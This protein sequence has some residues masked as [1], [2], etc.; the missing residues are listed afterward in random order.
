M[1]GDGSQETRR[2]WLEKRTLGG[3]DDSES[4]R[5]LWRGCA[6]QF[7]NVDLLIQHLNGHKER[8][9]IAGICPI[10]ECEF[11]EFVEQG[12]LGRH[13]SVHLHQLRLMNKGVQALKKRLE[14]KGPGSYYECKF[15]ANAKLLFD[16]RAM[17]CEWE[18]C[19]AYFSDIGH[20]ILHLEKHVKETY[21]DEGKKGYLCG[22]SQCEVVR[23]RKSLLLEHAR[24]HVGGKT[25][26]CPMC[27]SL[28]ASERILLQHLAR[29]DQDNASL[30]CSHCH[31]VFATDELLK[32]HLRRHLKANPCLT[33]SSI[34]DSPASLKRHVLTVHHDYRLFRCD[35]CRSTHGSASDLER[36]KAAV[37]SAVPSIFCTKCNASFRWRKQLLAHELTHN[38]NSI[39]EPYACHLCDSKYKTGFSLS[40]HL[41]S[42]HHI[43]IPTGFSRYQYKLCS[44]GY[45]RLATKVFVKESCAKA[46]TENQ[47][48]SAK[49]KFYELDFV[50]LSD[51][52]HRASVMTLFKAKAKH[53]LKTSSKI[54][55][56]IFGECI[57][58]ADTPSKYAKCII[59]LL[60]ERDRQQTTEIL[61]PVKPIPAK[62]VFELRDVPSTNATVMTYPGPDTVA[63]P[64]SSLKRRRIRRPR[65]VYRT[66]E[67]MEPLRR[68]EK[69]QLKPTNIRNLEMIRRY[70]EMSSACSKYLTRIHDEND[71]LYKQMK[72][73]MKIQMQPSVNSVI[74]E[75]TKFFQNMP[76]F[77]GSKMSIMS[78]KLLSFFP[79][80]QKTHLLSPSL[81]SFQKDG[82]WSLPDVLQIV[83]G[84]ESQANQLLDF[85]LDV[86][87]ASQTLQSLVDK[88]S[89]EMD[90]M[91]HEIYPQVQ[92]MQRLDRIWSRISSTY[93]DRQKQQF[94]ER[95]Y[96][97][98]EPYQLA[99]L[100]SSRIV[101]NMNIDLQTYS[102]MSVEQK[103]ARIEE[104]IRKLAALN[105]PDVKEWPPIYQNA[106]RNFVRRLKR[107]TDDET[108]AEHHFETLLPFSF[109]PLI[110]RGASLEVVTLSPHAFVAEIL[111][112]EA[113]TW[114]TLV[115]RAFIASVLSPNA[116][117]GR[118]LSPS[119]LRTEV[120]S[121]RALTPFI[122]SPEALM[123]DILSPKFL[124]TR[125]LAPE[126]LVVKVLSPNM[127]SE[128]PV[129]TLI[130][131]RRKRSAAPLT[132][133]VLS[134][135]RCRGDQPEARYAS[136]VLYRH[137]G[138]SE[139]AE[140]VANLT[141]EVV[142]DSNVKF[143]EYAP[144]LEEETRKR[145]IDGPKAAPLGHVDE[146]MSVFNEI[147]LSTKASTSTS[148]KQ[149]PQISD[150]TV[151]G[152]PMIRMSKELQPINDNEYIYDFYYSKNFNKQRPDEAGLSSQYFDVRVVKDD[153]D[154]A[155][156]EGDFIS[157][158]SDSDASFDYD[159]EDSNDENYYKNDYPDEESC[160]SCDDNDESGFDLYGIRNNRDDYNEYDDV[161]EET[162]EDD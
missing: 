52:Y 92:E 145:T 16:G 83:S 154:I 104:D 149:V 109:A 32:A 42:T 129:D 140:Q 59:P 64:A 50:K 152:A 87:G 98:L 46:F 76:I 14:E 101:P 110:G 108:A 128:E 130:R 136:V 47:L 127:A 81:L 44:D 124:E 125:V 23:N 150:I 89:A 93:N 116:L 62:E 123:I 38:E 153:N 84:G 28:F 51:Y 25:I 58:E 91:E 119:A 99:M 9:C 29:S 12:G 86:S 138:S 73:P 79:T 6:S 142:L 85:I 82:L 134:K 55:R 11:D 22:W 77:N 8:G 118:V 40:R 21:C 158:A 13:L 155:L 63:K 45:K 148:Q 19:S 137:V 143:I 72:I 162:D 26:A 60:D 131:I 106:Q 41:K 33:C 114:H 80:R 54:E 74:E 66:D 151:N 65:R 97:F 90:Q 18:Q 35:L 1:D 132:G 141:E 160:D 121:P 4:W 67:T 75:F 159:S 5:C 117:V 103:E 43:S 111:F 139:H 53:I 147:D 24:S 15:A 39:S 30:D 95:G 156:Y 27:G 102:K 17:V 7:V 135:K 146:L 70:Y 78:P 61:A 126:A 133:L 34:F 3:S 105:R 94:K 37:H 36:H 57:Q 31:K 68:R 107:Q 115:P 71:N 20:Y 69:R 49:S 113:L 157:Y 161:N 100:Y 10:S 2:F 96:A 56:I 88:M 120:L 122:L 144:S 112:P 48:T